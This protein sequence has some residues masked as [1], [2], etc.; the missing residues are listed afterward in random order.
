M[1]RSAASAE[2]TRQV[3]KSTPAAYEPLPLS[4]SNVSLLG[5]L[6]MA[7]SHASCRFR[8]LSPLFCKALRRL[9]SRAVEA[10]MLAFLSSS[11]YF[12][13]NGQ[14]RLH[15]RLRSSDGDGPLFLSELFWETACYSRRSGGSLGT[16]PAERARGIAHPLASDFRGEGEV[17]RAVLAQPCRQRDCVT[18]I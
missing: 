15:G 4:T 18:R 9:I 10:A 11:W 8:C 1:R 13:Y 7:P 14:G 17:A 6:C 3:E 12:W 5:I 16:E 2:I